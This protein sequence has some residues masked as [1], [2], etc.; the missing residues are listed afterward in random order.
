M[1]FSRW[2]KYLQYRSTVLSLLLPERCIHCDEPTAFSRNNHEDAFQLTHYLCKVC[3]RTT[4]HYDGPDEPTIRHQFALAAS[5]LPIAHHIGAYSFVVESPI[6]SIIHAFKYL[7]MQRLAE[8]LGQSISTLLPKR[9]DYIIPVPL[10][11][12]RLAER[13]YNQAESLAEGLAH[14]STATVLRATKRIRPTPSQTFLSIP[15]R[16]ANMEGA[17][18]LTRHA[19]VIKNKDV[20][21]VDDVMTT[22]STI[23]SVAETVLAAKPKS[24]SVLTMAIAA[25]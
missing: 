23:A 20:L 1:R 12:T 19:D 2:K 13:G 3:Y 24:I 21:I 14:T 18:A 17:F 9:L 6:Q 10:H 7:R 8:G 4:Q 15:E 5:E 11:R 25:G 16:I 22:G